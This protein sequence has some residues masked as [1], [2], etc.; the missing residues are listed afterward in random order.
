[1]V[2]DTFCPSAVYGASQSIAIP[3]QVVESFKTSNEFAW[4]PD[5]D[6][7]FDDGSYVLQYDVGDQ[8]RLIAFRCREDGLHDSATLSELWLESDAFYNILKIMVA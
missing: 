2:P 1:L 5:G 8:V 7:A 3:E 6:A 4:A